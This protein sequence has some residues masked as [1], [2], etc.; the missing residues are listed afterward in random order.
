MPMDGAWVTVTASA[1][2][3]ALVRPLRDAML[4]I[5]L[6]MLLLGLLLGAAS[7]LQL[8]LGLRP[9][10]RVTNDLENVRAGRANHIGG[11]QPRE[12]SGL[13]NELNSLISQN[14]EGIKRARGHVSNLGHAL[15]TPLAA[16][17]LSLGDGGDAADR[18]RL[19]LVAEMQERIRHHLAR[20]RAGILHGPGHMHTAVNPRVVDIKNVL[21]KVHA[22]RG[23]A[24]TTDVPESLA[25]ACEPQDLDEMLGN[26]LDNAFKWARSAVR[27]TGRSEG[28]RIVLE[29]ADDGPGITND[30]LDDVLKAGRKLDESVAGHGFGLSI[31]RELAELYG[32]DVALGPSAAGGL[33]I[34]ISLPAA[35]IPV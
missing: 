24:V 16:L 31:T 14:A 18:E 35:T 19:A 11:D 3:H 6:S 20:A 12:L 33:K 28:N 9:L 26:I 7:V 27:V 30:A 34:T 1:P 22:D 8:R 15:N 29:I 21:L 13:V 25:V 5:V 2:A 4:P 23:L 32:G 17:A 10:A